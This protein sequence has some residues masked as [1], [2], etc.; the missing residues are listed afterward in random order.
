M[1]CELFLHLVD[2]IC[3]F[4]L[5]FIQNHDALERLGLSSL[6][7]YTIALRM[8]AYGLGADACDEPVGWKSPLPWRP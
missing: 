6:Q 4:D 8:L 7:K 1:R 2:A 3:C 5:W